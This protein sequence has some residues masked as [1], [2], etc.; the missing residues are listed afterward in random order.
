MESKKICSEENQVENNQKVNSNIEEGVSGL[1]KKECPKDFK[2]VLK[3]DFNNE[4]NSEKKNQN[5]Y[6]SYNNLKNIITIKE[7]SNN[8]IG[9]LLN[10]NTL[11]IYN[12]KTFS[13][14]NEIK[15][16]NSDENDTEKEINE[17]KN[18]REIIFNFIELKNFYL[19]F[20]TFKTIFFYK[21]SENG[22][23]LYQT[24][25]ESNEEHKREFEDDFYSMRRNYNRNGYTIN[26]IYQLKNDNLLCCY[27]FGIKIYTKNNDNYILLLK[28]ETNVEV[29]NIFEIEPNKCVLMQKNF[30]S[31]GFCSQTY[32][33]V[34]TYS[35]SLYDIE[36]D[37]L[38]NLNE[39][40]ERVSLDQ[41]YISFFNNENYLFVKYGE[42]KYDIYDINQNMNSINSN[43]EIIETTEVKELYNFFR[44]REYN[45]IKDE[46][47]IRFLCKYS[48]ELFFAADMNN[49]IKLY[50]FKDKSFEFY[51]DFPLSN[52][53]IAG[54]IKLKNNSII[55]YTN[56]NF[57]VINDC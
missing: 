14:I 16:K 21:P 15:I 26:T 46:M 31:G 34:H 45:K 55:M 22:Y 1:E 27:T 10:T 13:K 52:K 54:M 28:H 17:L 57:F 8:R 5:T 20:W 40:K 43:N 50:K 38:N 30:E 12:S 33:C 41:N 35:L 36:K 51:Q 39:F 29:K 3:I 4:N 11:L 48:K 32:Y 44:E 6:H 49:D 2:L 19:V 37:T 18:E 53:E 25:D 7:I 47:N 56:Q 42:F 24:I 23:T 9:V